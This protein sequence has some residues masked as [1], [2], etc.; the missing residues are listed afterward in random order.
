MSTSFLITIKVESPIHL[1]SGQADVNIDSDVIH[2]RWGLPYFPARTFRGLLYESA[3]ELL[4]M[5]ELSG[6]SFITKE[7]I[8]NL[9]NRGDIENPNLIISN[10]FIENYAMVS[11]QW[12]YLQ[13]KYSQFFNSK[14]VLESYSSIRYQMKKSYK[15][16]LTQQGSLH[17]MRVIDAGIVFYGTIEVLD[18]T[19]SNE[20]LLALL[21]QNTRVAGLK[22]NRGFGRI[23]CTIDNQVELVAKRL[24]GAY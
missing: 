17:N 13:T 4:E 9:F 3:L 10:F 21:L 14:S 12:D 20:S 1:S 5:A 15:N 7:E 8:E 6:A 2:D 23:T 24:E 22:R 19:A 16:G 18:D 11:K